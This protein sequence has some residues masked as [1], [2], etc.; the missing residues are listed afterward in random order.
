MAKRTLTDEV[1]IERSRLDAR[2]RP[3]DVHAWL[4]QWTERLARAAKRVR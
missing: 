3:K 2:G 1:M 4:R